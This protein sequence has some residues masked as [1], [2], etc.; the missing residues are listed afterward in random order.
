MPGPAS[1]RM[2]LGAELRKVREGAGRSTRQ[3]APFSSGHISNVERGQ[4]LPSEDLVL[5]YAGL[6]GSHAQL[7]GLLMRAKEP[8][9]PVHFDDADLDD[10]STDPHV[11]RRGYVV[12]AVEDVHFYGPQRQPTRTMH[13]A[14]IRLQD[15]ARF[16]PFRHTLEE[17]PRPGVSTIHPGDGC[18]VALVEEGEDGTLYAVLAVDPSVRDELGRSTFGW[19][20]ELD[21]TAVGQPRILGGSRSRIPA[22]T[23]RAHFDP[24][25]VPGEVWWFRD[26][27][28]SGRTLS[29]A[30]RNRLRPNLAHVFTHE[31]VNVQEEWWG[32]AWSWPE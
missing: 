20:I 4:V 1:P 26:F 17:D 12:E 27:D 8:P 14:T 22:A 30:R 31:F 25:A 16:F 3:M 9:R 28:I 29:Q 11:L 18:E 5:L 7:T 24:T 21:T 32:L 15:G 2:L 6:G 13:R 23:K 19:T 10:P